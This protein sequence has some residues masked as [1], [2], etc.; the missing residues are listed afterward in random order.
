MKKIVYAPNEQY[1]E[2]VITDIT[3]MAITIEMDGRLGR[4]ALARRM[5]IT[6]NQPKIGDKVGFMLSYPEVLNNE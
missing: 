5:V 1:Y 2:G 6:E 3:D 4:L